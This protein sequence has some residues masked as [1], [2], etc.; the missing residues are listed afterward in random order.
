[1]FVLRAACLGALLALTSGCGSTIGARWGAISQANSPQYHGEHAK[2][3]SRC[4]NGSFMSDAPRC[5]YAVLDWRGRLIKLHDHVF[6][7]SDQFLMA[8]TEFAKWIK[9]KNSYGY[10]G[11]STLDQ[12]PFEI[13]VLTVSP[14]VLL[15]VPF[16]RE[17]RSCRNEDAHRLGC[18]QS[19]RLDQ[20]HYSLQL[21]PS[22]VS[23]S[24]WFMPEQK[25]SEIHLIE[26]NETSVTIPLDDSKLTLSVSAGFWEVSRK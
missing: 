10:G 3:H 22:V 21:S 5:E 24:F 9:A 20:L 12:F 19:E 13:H 1:M 4:R 15:A 23:G 17:T 2:V 7:V 6:K 25:G 14:M 26:E 18:W 16:D 11:S 8:R